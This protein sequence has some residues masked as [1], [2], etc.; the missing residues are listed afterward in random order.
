M[1]VY[2]VYRCP[3]AAPA[4]MHRKRFEGDNLLDWFR[5]H[6]D[7]LGDDSV[8][9]LLGCHVY[10]FPLYGGEDGERLPPPTTAREL[11]EYLESELYTN[12]MGCDSAHALQ[13]STDDDEY[14]LACYFFDD[15]FLK[16]YRK[17]AAF[18]LLDDW[19]LPGGAGPGGFKTT[20]L[21]TRV[22]GR[23]VWE[24]TTYVVDLDSVGDMED[25]SPAYRIDGTRLPELAKY[26]LRTSVDETAFPGIL[27]APRALLAVD[28]AK[29]D[30]LERAFLRDIRDN[31]ADE[32]AWNAYSDWLQ[33]RGERPAGLHLLHRAL[34]RAG[35]WDD[36]EMRPAGPEGLDVWEAGVADAPVAYPAL[37]KLATAIDRRLGKSN[38]LVHVD[39]HVAQLCLHH[40][41]WSGGNRH[42]YHHWILFD[43]LWAGAHPDLANAI[44]RYSY[45]WDVLSPRRSQQSD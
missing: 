2:F 34:T 29:T 41:Y 28:G 1:S 6:W 3:Y 23:G 24:G 38:S 7:Q 30:P 10:S 4:G 15:H 9:E 26:L 22:K 16:K 42:I 8:D 14:G 19:R 18:L 33:E 44:L 21:T 12:E 25:L 32:A 20:E 31:P 35:V 45:K 17:R 13:I 40:H 37:R 39:E 27:V 11:A 36:R 5:D 43:D